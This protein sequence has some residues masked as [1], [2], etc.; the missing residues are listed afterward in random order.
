MKSLPAFILAT[1][2]VAIVWALTSIV[3]FHLLS[4][5]TLELVYKPSPRELSLLVVCSG[6]GAL[7]WYFISAEIAGLTTRRAVMGWTMVQ[8]SVLLLSLPF[9]GDSFPVLMALCAGLGFMGA[10][11][12]SVWFPMVMEVNHRV[13]PTA[14]AAFFVSLYTVAAV[15]IPAFSE[16]LAKYGSMTTLL[17]LGAASLAGSCLALVASKQML[18][19]SRGNAPVT[20]FTMTRDDVANLCNLSSIF[21]FMLGLLIFPL[22]F[23]T[24]DYLL[25]AFVA[26]NTHLKYSDV[27]W[28]IG[29]GRVPAVAILL[30]AMPAIRSNVPVRFFGVGLTVAALGM[31]GMAK[32]SDTIEFI[33]VYLVYYLG[34]GLCLSALYNSIVASVVRPS[35]DVSLLAGGLVLT[36]GALGTSGAHFFLLEIGLDTGRLFLLCAAVPACAGAILALGSFIRA[37]NGANQGG[38]FDDDTPVRNTN[39][40]KF[41][42]GNP[43][44]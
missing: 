20:F 30:V 38:H 8:S 43:R 19:P 28:I 15:C 2:G 34:I 36:M 39:F 21:L 26:E 32:V 18:R 27:S 42:Y 7:G 33:A 9:L 44:G 13:R 6:G 17:G 16:L 35:R 4:A 29:I 25:P 1:V 5:E 23:L 37:L 14:V 40:K 22:L 11:I 41:K 31:I 10:S 24:G 12:W 3:P